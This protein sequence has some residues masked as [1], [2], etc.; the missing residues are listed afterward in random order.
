MTGVRISDRA[1]SEILSRTRQR[2]LQRTNDK[3]R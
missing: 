3:E 1:F 2:R